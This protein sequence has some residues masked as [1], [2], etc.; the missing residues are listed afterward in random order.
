MKQESRLRNE[1]GAV[2]VVALMMLVLLTI[3]GI[4]VSST[5]EVELQIAGNEM[6]YKENLYKAD[7][8]A[9]ACAQIMEQTAGIDISIEDDFIIPFTAGETLETQGWI[10]DDDF[11]EGL[12]ADP[13]NVTD[14]FTP[15][16]VDAVL[17]PDGNSRYVAVYIGVPP[18][19]DFESGLR[20]F[21]IYGRSTG[22]QGS[23]SLIRM[24]YRR[25]GGIVE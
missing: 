10:R 19:E 9:M 6:R 7:A 5:S 23:R 3:L 15:G 8:A 24:G 4:S 21:T 20:E 11:W 12:Y 1:D 14:E 22:I 2:L 18:G 17:D 25:V 13:D 16:T